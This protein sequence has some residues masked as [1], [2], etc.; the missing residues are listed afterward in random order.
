MKKTHAENKRIAR[1]RKRAQ[2]YIL[3]QIW[4]KPEKWPKIK[5]MVKEI[6]GLKG[7]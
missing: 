2:G 3:K 5:G 1:D 7:E 4:V 6:N